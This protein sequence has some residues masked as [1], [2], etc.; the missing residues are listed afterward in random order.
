MTLIRAS[1]G[2]LSSADARAYCRGF[3]RFPTSRVRLTLVATVTSFQR[4]FVERKKKYEMEWNVRLCEMLN[5]PT[6]N[7]SR[8]TF[9]YRNECACHHSYLIN[10]FFLLQNEM[11]DNMLCMFCVLGFLN[12]E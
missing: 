2:C 7:T 1:V 4:M 12:V 8:Y 5:T 6:P 3:S 10:F 11:F 9:F